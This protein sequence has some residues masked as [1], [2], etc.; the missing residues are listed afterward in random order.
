MFNTVVTGD[1]NLDKIWLPWL[2]KIFQILPFVIGVLA[3]IVVVILVLGYLGILSSEQIKS[4]ERLGT[5]LVS[6]NSN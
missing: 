2:L 1:M 6:K 5:G 4:I 3:A